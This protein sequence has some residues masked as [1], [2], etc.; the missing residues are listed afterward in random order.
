LNDFS[1]KAECQVRE[2]FQFSAQAQYEDWKFPALRI[3][4]ESDFSSSV[5]LTFQ[6]KRRWVKN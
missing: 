1:V 5:Q 2:R 6:P 4:P 3:G